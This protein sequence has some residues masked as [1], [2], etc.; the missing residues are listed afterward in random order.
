MSDFSIDFKS[1]PLL[2]STPCRMQATVDNAPV[3]YN[4]SLL[5]VAY[6]VALYRTAD[7]FV[8]VYRTD[9]NSEI[10]I[11]NLN[12]FGEDG[13]EEFLQALED[14]CSIINLSYQEGVDD[15]FAQTDKLQMMYDKVMKAQ[16]DDNT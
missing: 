2:A 4:G 8:S 11:Y 3:E 14:V 5:R 1:K 9:T 12:R 15:A 10:Q 6:L 16:S 7:I 13:E